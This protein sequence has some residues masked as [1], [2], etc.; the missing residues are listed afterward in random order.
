MLHHNDRTNNTTRIH[1]TH[2]SSFTSHVR[3]CGTP[4]ALAQRSS[5]AS[6]PLRPLRT[7]PLGSMRYS[8]GT[9]RRSPSQPPSPASSRFGAACVR[10][11]ACVC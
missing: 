9:S 3:T 5:S 1:G 10:V 8:L 7:P 2:D 11:C 4:S 6:Q